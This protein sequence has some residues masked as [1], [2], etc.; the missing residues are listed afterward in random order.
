MKNKKVLVLHSSSDLYG[1][2]NSVFR[3]LLALQK[4]GM[5]PTLLLSEKGLLSEKV[6]KEGL[7]VRILRLGVLRRKYFNFFG[8]I[9][10]L[11][12]IFKATLK[13]RLLIKK[14]GFGLVVSNASVILPGAFA[15]KLT[16]TKHVW[17]IREIIVKPTI[18]KNIITKILNFTGDLNV[19]V[20]KA[21]RDNYKPALD[22]SKAQVIYN[23]IDY[24]VFFNNKYNLKKEINVCQDKIVI[25]MI[26]RVNLW[27]GQKYFIEIAKNLLNQN[28]NLHFVLVG[29][30]YPGFEYLI[31]EFQEFLK[32]YQLNE[33][34][35]NLGFREDTYNILA[36]SDI[37]VLPSTSPDP[38]PT[39]VLEAMAS[40]RSVIA[41]NHGG[42]MEMVVD[43]ET[44]FLIPWNDALKAAVVIQKLI[45]DTQLRTKMG[46]KG[47]ERL[48]ANFSI[49]S[50]LDNFGKE[51]YKVM[52]FEKEK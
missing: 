15:A 36:G 37:F 25:T 23:G 34:F 3:S 46:I 2:S 11:Y 31:D 48:V 52:N 10:R 26:A 42:A 7:N 30:A 51:I 18:V 5:E 40:A 1:A 41:T 9:N 20:S 13:I 39:T 49:D 43:G 16:G 33:S 8:L 35:S 29:D 12:F 21:A 32:K 4:I 45:D 6:E 44:G 47:Q 19:F 38:L 28:N 24:N 14:E 17:H 27:K 50:Y 22:L